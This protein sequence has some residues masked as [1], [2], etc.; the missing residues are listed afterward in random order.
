MSPD[1]V[2]PNMKLNSAKAAWGTNA[3]VRGLTTLPVHV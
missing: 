3:A 1:P 2:L